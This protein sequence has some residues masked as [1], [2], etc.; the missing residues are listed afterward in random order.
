MQNERKLLGTRK[1]GEFVIKKK[2]KKSLNKE[3]QKAQKISIGIR[4]IL[5]IGFN[6]HLYIQLS[7]R[8]IESC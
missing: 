6:A 3:N 1:K 5:S 2:E 4:K 8:T 7:C